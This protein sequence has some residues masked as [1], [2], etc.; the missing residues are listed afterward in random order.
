[1][2]VPDDSPLALAN[3]KSL[4][5]SNLPV[6]SNFD[7]PIDQFPLDKVEVGAGF[8][9]PLSPSKLVGGSAQLAVSG[10]LDATLSICTPKQK[11]LFGDDEFAPSIQ[12]KAGECWAGFSIAAS[13]QESA[14]TS[15]SGI[16]VVVTA[17]MTVTLGTMVRF[18]EPGSAMPSFKD[19]LS[20]LLKDYSVPYTP[21]KIR[22]TPLGIAYSAET[23]GVI[24]LGA[25]YSAPLEMNPLASLG[26]PFNLSLAVQPD[27]KA[28]IKGSITLAGSFIF[29]AYREAAGKLIVGLYKQKKTTLSAAFS[30]SAGIGVD[31]DKTDILAQVLNAVLPSADLDNLHL[32]HGQKAELTKALKGCV[33][34]SISIA[35]NAACSASV[36][37]EAAVIYELDLNVADLSRTDVAL[38]AALKGD[39]SAIDA[40][41]NARRLR[42]IVRELHERNHKL[43]INLLGLYN[44][45]SI[46]DY[47]TSTT[48]VHDE[49]GQVA[50]MDKVAAQTLSA[51]TTPYAAK[52]DKLR[53]VLAQA[54]IA[55]VAYGASAGKIGV[56]SFAVQQ[57]LLEYKAQAN[58]SD[59]LR[60]V[61]L[62]RSVGLALNSEW[63][64][65]VKSGGTFNHSKFYLD[66]RYDAHSVMHLF[67]Q[68]VD[69]RTPYPPA[70]LDKIGRETKIALLDPSATNSMQ[71]RMALSRD[72]IW[73]AMNAC[74]NVTTFKSVPGLGRLDP[75]AIAAITADFLDIRWW[76]DALHSLTPKLTALLDAADQ[77]TTPNPLTDP[78]FMAAHKNLESALA[79][80]STKTQGAFGEGWG[81]AVMCRLAVSASSAEVP[82]VQMDIGWNQKFEHYESG[83]G[84]AVG[85]SSGA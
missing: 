64:V 44:A 18:P 3:L 35:L 37:D 80:L 76:S 45:T 8:G 79:H 40:L 42:N 82:S 62:A 21:E 75:T 6:I 50:I 83:V 28:S 27:A 33:D 51:G 48:V 24:S 46:A 23:S 16:G 71:R 38:A 9:N 60:Q 57:S 78:A 54:F 69:K 11:T 19:G 39:W 66:A 65:L 34:Q 61:L 36:T 43:T 2:D 7:K 22:A 12:I 81:L 74:G 49:N 47:V 56:T 72:D 55:T 25:V 14:G 84:M 67:Y 4:N 77:S 20:T 10:G 63:D 68:D 59:L 1:V 17:G 26:L 53:S 41:T 13:I 30:E 29:R 70:T 5:F 58:C 32:D 73:A 85:Q 52:T 15:L 31:V